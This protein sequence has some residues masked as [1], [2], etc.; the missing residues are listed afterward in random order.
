MFWKSKWER[1]VYAVIFLMTGFISLI[2]DFNAGNGAAFSTLVFLFIGSLN[3]ILFAFKAI[4]KRKVTSNLNQK[5]NGVLY[6]TKWKN[7]L[8]GLF[9]LLI[10]MILY[11]KKETTSDSLAIQLALLFG[12]TE[13]FIFIVKFFNLNKSKQID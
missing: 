10:G 7:G 1:L 13:T 9:F 6:T 3:L 4:R 12:A 8:Y 11:F 2:V 5:L